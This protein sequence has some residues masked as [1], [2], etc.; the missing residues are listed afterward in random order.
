MIMDWLRKLQYKLTTRMPSPAQFMEYTEATQHLCGGD[1]KWTAAA[2][3]DLTKKGLYPNPLSFWAT[4]YDERD[5]QDKA[6][7]LASSWLDVTFP[8]EEVPDRPGVH[9]VYP[10][11]DRPGMHIVYW[12]GL[13]GPCNKE[14]LSRWW[15]SK[16][17][18]SG[19][20]DPKW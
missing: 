16:A 18:E 15:K 2:I 13:V 1:H 19:E 14:S 6:R 3:V 9:T 11:P 8:S 7:D 12:P 17:S 5:A 20:P 10:H 4:A